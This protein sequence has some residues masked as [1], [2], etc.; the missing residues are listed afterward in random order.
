MQAPVGRLDAMDVASMLWQ[1]LGRDMVTSAT[2]S[3]MGH[4]VSKRLPS[5]TVVVLK[6]LVLPPLTNAQPN[7]VMRYA[8]RYRGAQ[9]TASSGVAKGFVRA[10]KTEFR[11]F[12]DSCG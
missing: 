6:R 8:L 1:R 3:I 2:L 9:K 4:S 12:A 11:L 5:Q 7:S 10:K